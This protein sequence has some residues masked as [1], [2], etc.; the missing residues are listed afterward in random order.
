[1][2]GTAMARA[3]RKENRAN[4]FLMSLN[5]IC[6]RDCEGL[7]GDHLVGGAGIS[8]C[9]PEGRFEPQVVYP[10]IRGKLRTKPRKRGVKRARITDFYTIDNEAYIP[11]QPPQACK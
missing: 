1:M 7:I 6:L 9:A 5:R 3:S 8:N 4:V 2:F 10:Q 11:A